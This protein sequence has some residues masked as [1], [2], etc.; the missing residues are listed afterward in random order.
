MKKIL[1]ILIILLLSIIQV[2]ADIFGCT[3]ICEVPEEPIEYTIP[4][5]EGSGYY[6]LS[7]GQVIYQTIE[8]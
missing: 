7:E 6:E 4:K 5:V 2:H 8:R 3:V 1:P